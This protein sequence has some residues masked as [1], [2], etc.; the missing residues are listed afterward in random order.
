M[1]DDGIGWRNFDALHCRTRAVWDPRMLHIAVDRVPPRPAPADSY[2]VAASIVP[3]SGASV[4]ADVTRVRWR[5]AGEAG[6][7]E[8]ALERSGDGRFRA[9]IP[10]G[11]SARVVE[12]Y[13][14]AADASPRVETA[15]RTA[16][17]AVFRFT[18]TPR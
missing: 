8:A 6:W 18:P 3:Y 16:P 13:V 7:R 1:Y 10:A 15:P 14:V 5:Y 4:L 2:G 17:G 9:S 12:Y 11:P